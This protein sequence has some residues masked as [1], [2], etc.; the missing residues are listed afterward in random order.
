MLSRELYLVAPR[1]P[2]IVR[3]HDQPPS[4]HR[5]AAP[6]GFLVLAV[7]T[8]VP[9]CCVPTIDRLLVDG[10]SGRRLA[11]ARG[12]I[13]EATRDGLPYEIDWGSAEDAAAEIVAEVRDSVEESASLFAAT[14]I[15]AAMRD[16]RSSA[17][18]LRIARHVYAIAEVW[19]RTI[20]DRELRVALAA[21]IDGPLR[22]DVAGAEGAGARLGS[23]FVPLDTPLPSSLLFE[24]ET[25]R[26][27]GLRFH[28][29][30]EIATAIRY[31]REESGS[32]ALA[33]VV[34]RQLGLRGRPATRL[35][36]NPDRVHQVALMLYHVQEVDPR[37]VG[38]PTTLRAGAR[39]VLRRLGT[40]EFG[41]DAFNQ[42]CDR[43]DWR[44]VAR[45]PDASLSAPRRISA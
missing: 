19:L 1:E 26:R 12:P 22:T 33:G 20:D 5:C 38:C 16:T 10:G 8:R 9:S 45:M 40:T 21:L 24:R 29:L 35:V 44:C 13:L 4:A 43:G 3:Y 17:W 2:A 28:R 42:V 36:D 23:A 39:E 18:R 7:P 31:L 41:A 11:G 34:E 14:P 27:P 6:R 30:E 32:R 37:S 25:R 15:G